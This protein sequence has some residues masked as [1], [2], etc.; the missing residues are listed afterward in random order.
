MTAARVRDL[1]DG[2]LETSEA[3]LADGT[4][5]RAEPRAMCG[6][7][8][9]RRDSSR[10]SRSTISARCRG[11]GPRRSGRERRRVGQVDKDSR[12]ER[13]RRARRSRARGARIAQ[14]CGSTLVAVRARVA[15]PPS[16]LTRPVAASPA[17]RAATTA[18]CSA[19]SGAVVAS[20]HGGR[21]RRPRRGTQEK[22]AGAR[23]L[24]SS[25][26]APTRP[27]RGTASSVL[28]HGTSALQP[29]AAPAR[30][31]A[32]AVRGDRRDVRRGDLEPQAAREVLEAEVHDGRVRRPRRAQVFVEERGDR[33]RRRRRR[34]AAS[35]R[36]TRRRP[37]RPRPPART[38]R[39]ARARRPRPGCRRARGRLEPGDEH[40]PRAP[41]GA[42]GERAAEA[43]ARARAATRARRRRSRS[44]SSGRA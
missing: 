37:R 7:R 18:A 13:P 25:P 42:G 39:R 22:G 20:R 31:R 19:A 28:L 8:S 6:A 16:P 36:S 12:Q 29:A 30:R 35:R 4:G 15:A 23:G 44:S 10:S 40:A 26:T 14:A 21:R 27:R 11:S 34:A 43:R 38:C 2:L 33:A 3:R 41:A 24:S 32:R 5:R 17:A 9:S 1:R